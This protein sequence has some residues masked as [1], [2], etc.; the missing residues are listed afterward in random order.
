MKSTFLEMFGDTA[1]NQMKWD[2]VPL[3]QFGKIITGNTPSRSNAENYS[4]N[5]IE[6][7]KTDN[8]KVDKTYI[9]QASEYLS[10]LGLKNAR[11]INS[12]A[13]L[14]ACIAGSIESVGRAALT[15]RIVSFNQQINAIQP[16]K[17]IEPLFLY[18]VFKISKNYIQGHATK[19]MKKILT[20]GEFEKIKMI[21][22]PLELQTKFSQIVEKANA[23]KEQY[24]ESLQELENLYRSLSQQ[25]FKGELDLSKV[26]IEE[27]EVVEVEDISLTK[28]MKLYVEQTKQIQKQIEVQGDFVDNLRLTLKNIEEIKVLHESFS[29]SRQL[30]KIV[31]DAQKNFEQVLN[32]IPVLDYTHTKIA[33]NWAERV[34]ETYNNIN[35]SIA[36]VSEIIRPIEEFGSYI[37]PLNSLPVIPPYITDV[38]KN[39][40][41]IKNSLQIGRASCRERV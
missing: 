17:E 40:E 34:Q 15:N 11:T 1:L 13:L 25:A 18:W 27:E 20:K 32:S 33:L 19:G 9:T 22:P 12:G 37:A 24:L 29:K 10:E 21:K 6:W 31:I 39:V 26:E 8:I 5:F 23:I 4:S 16:N 30:P 14:I 38:L 2:K 3:K 35:K 28:E 7:I 41:K 36:R